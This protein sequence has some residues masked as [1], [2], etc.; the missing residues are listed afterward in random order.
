MALMDAERTDL[1]RRARDRRQDAAR[2]WG[3]ASRLDLL[4]NPAGQQ[5]GGVIGMLLAS[6]FRESAAARGAIR[7]LQSRS[8]NTSP[9]FCGFALG[10]LFHAV[11]LETLDEKD[12]AEQA[13]RV[14]VVLAPA[15]AAVGDRFVFGGVQPVLSALVAATA[16]LLPRSILPEV[17]AGYVI[18]NL[19]LQAFWRRRAWIIGLEREGAVLSFL[20]GRTLERW[21]R[22]HR[23]I[24]HVAAGAAVGGTIV[25]AA[26]RAEPGSLLVLC[27][28]LLAVGLW[29]RRP[30]AGRFRA[31]ALFLWALLFAW[32]RWTG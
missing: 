3:G 30:G 21:I 6:P 11:A 23:G 7:V 1:R 17:L 27:G 12:G 5:R 25:L 14:A 20:R 8:F 24:V 18:L 16:V 29:V 4:Y 15:L 32:T 28:G 2:Y 22:I 19:M 26:R 31:A 13:E 10:P 9:L